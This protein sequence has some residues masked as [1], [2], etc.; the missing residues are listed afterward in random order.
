M[1]SVTVARELL[2]RL[3]REARRPGSEHGS[4][5]F[6]VRTTDGD[7]AAA[8]LH[9]ASLRLIA[10][11]E[12]GHELEEWADTGETYTP[13]WVSPVYLSDHGPWLTG[14][15]QGVFY[16]AMVRAMVDVI[17]EELHRH[18]V[19]D[20]QVEEAPSGLPSHQS[21]TLPTPA[22][23]HP[24]PDGPRAWVLVRTRRRHTTT[25]RMWWAREYFATDGTW[26]PDSRK[27]LLFPDGP[28]RDLAHQLIADH[29]RGPA[30][31]PINSVYAR[32]DGYVRAGSTPPR[33]LWRDD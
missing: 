14:D 15:S 32:V 2:E 21:W 9:A 22:P 4:P 20:A 29:P 23:A 8:A 26:T 24:E 25:D 1:S 3:A 18:G 5:A 13:N 28:P 10:I 19:E 12:E 17:V 27:A 31:G 16:V 6:L 30:F 33:E 11:D 7:A